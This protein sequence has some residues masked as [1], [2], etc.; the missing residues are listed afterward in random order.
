MLNEE[1]AIAATLRALRRGAPKAEIIAV[2]GGSDDHSIAVARPLANRVIAGPRGR[3]R[4]MNA[5]ARAAKPSDV[6]V[7]VHADTI[8][9]P[10]FARQ[11]DRA[12]LDTRS[13]ADASISN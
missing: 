7:F 10:D 6:L 9:P 4:Q 12:L 1:R 5:G 8:V 2:D 11:I 3:A 13:S